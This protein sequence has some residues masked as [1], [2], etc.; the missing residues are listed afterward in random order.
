MIRCVLAVFHHPLS[1]LRLLTANKQF[2]LCGL[3]IH[4]ILCLGTK[5]SPEEE[6]SYQL[7]WHVI[8]WHV[9]QCPLDV[10]KTTKHEWLQAEKRRLMLSSRSTLHTFVY[11]LFISCY[12]SC[13]TYFFCLSSFYC[14]IANGELWSPALIAP[15]HHGL[16]LAPHVC[17]HGASLPGEAHYHQVTDVSIQSNEECEGLVTWNLLSPE[18]NGERFMETDC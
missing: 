16:N 2:L 1:L 4:A 6:N 17:P 14:N 10:A 13:H 15:R 5:Q 7:H 12:V 9:W 8:I 3:N 11:Y 18:I